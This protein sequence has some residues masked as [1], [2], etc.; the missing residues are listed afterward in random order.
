M[1]HG[2]INGTLRAMSDAFQS[3]EHEQERDM[4]DRALIAMDRLKQ[5]VNKDKVGSGI[6]REHICQSM[7]EVLGVRYTERELSARTAVAKTRMAREPKK[8]VSFSSVMNR[9]A[10]LVI[11]ESAG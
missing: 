1:G 11:K 4:R 3:I 2:R 7:K 10:D 8:P 5:I 6:K 9:A